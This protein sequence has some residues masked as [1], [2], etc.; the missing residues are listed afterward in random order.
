[1]DDI[2]SFIERRLLGRKGKLPLIHFKCDE[3]GHFVAR[4][5]NK[6]KSDINN[7]NDI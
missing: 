1:M 4:C 6:R 5:P 2:E 3:V 7:N